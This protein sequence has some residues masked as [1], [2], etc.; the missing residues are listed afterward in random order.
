MVIEF[1][2]SGPPPPSY[3]ET[4]RSPTRLRQASAGP[5]E[6]EGRMRKGEGGRGALR[7]AS[8]D[9]APLREGASPKP[10]CRPRDRRSGIRTRGA[11]RESRG[12]PTVRAPALPRW[13]G[14]TGTGRRE[15][16]RGGRK[17]ERDN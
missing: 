10:G 13:S 15:G 2:R 1:D 14:S 16:G 9:R 3:G 5:P 12:G 7:G 17:P 6:P 11:G 4:R 8:G